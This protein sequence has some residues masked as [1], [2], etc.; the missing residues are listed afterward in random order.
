MNK[1]IYIIILLII[2]ILLGICITPCSKY[3]LRCRPPVG[4]KKCCTKK[5]VF[6]LDKVTKLMK[7]K[8]FIICGTLLA[9]KRYEGKHMIPH[10]DDADGCILAKDEYYFKNIIPILKS[11][12]FVVKL[13]ISKKKRKG[14]NPANSKDSKNIIEYPPY[15][16]YSIRYSL[17]N[18]LHIDVAILNPSYLEDSTP[19]YIDAPIEWSKS[20]NKMDHII[21]N[22]Y[23]SWIM[24][25][26]EL[27]PIIKDKYLGINIYRPLKMDKVLERMYGES[28]MIPYNRNK[29]KNTKLIT[30][31]G[32]E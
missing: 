28:Y 23:R 1:T 31:D 15:R 12:G 22:K 29:Y 3:S 13:N 10:D 19:V 21:A 16:Y 27:L 17:I 9:L 20:V 24:Y 7:G 14:K 6:M 25:E 4:S 30:L 8:F 18:N 26:D 2:V 5:I 32:K 11:Y